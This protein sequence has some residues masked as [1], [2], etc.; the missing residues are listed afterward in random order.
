MEFQLERMILFRV[1]IFAIA[2]RL[3]TIVLK[4]PE[5]PKQ[6]VSDAKLAMP[7]VN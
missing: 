2:V 4:I 5:I 6:K 3:L 7:L 1:A